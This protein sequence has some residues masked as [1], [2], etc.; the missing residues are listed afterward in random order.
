MAQQ[1]KGAHHN[2]RSRRLQEMNTGH[3]RKVSVVRCMDT[4]PAGVLQT[5]PSQ[6]QQA[7]GLGG[8]AE[9]EERSDAALLLPFGVAR[10]ITFPGPCWIPQECRFAPKKASVR[11]EHWQ[12]EK[13]EDRESPSSVEGRE[14]AL[15]GPLR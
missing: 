7:R 10:M 12:Q 3:C 15:S 13:V 8:K 2:P 4:C 11:G 1:R 6:P 14:K 5:C 9:G